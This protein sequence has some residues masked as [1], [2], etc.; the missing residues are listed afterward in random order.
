M[1]AAIRLREG[2]R[3][4]LELV[5]RDT[6]GAER[7]MLRDRETRGAERVDRETDGLDRLDRLNERAEALDLATSLVRPGVKAKEIDK[8]VRQ[9]IRDAG[10]PIYP[11]HTGHGIGAASHEAPRIVPYSEEVLEEGMVIMLEPGIYIPGITGVR[12][13]DGLLVT[14]DGAEV[15]S[16]HDKGLP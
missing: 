8:R 10:Y 12:L 3:D 1:L 7:L 16:K 9:Y 2:D 5:E 15:L 13:E 14:A 11:H 6:R 4:R